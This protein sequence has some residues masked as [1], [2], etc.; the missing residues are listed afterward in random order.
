MFQFNISSLLFCFRCVHFSLPLSVPPAVWYVSGGGGYS[1]MLC[2]L[3]HSQLSFPVCPKG[4]VSLPTEQ[5]GVLWTAYQPGRGK[6]RI[7]LNFSGKVMLLV[8]LPGSILA[9][10]SC[11]YVLGS[12]QPIAW[13]ILCNMW[14]QN[15][16]PCQPITLQNQLL[17]LSSLL[18]LL[19]HGSVWLRVH[20]S[21][22]CLRWRRRFQ[23]HV[24]WLTNS[25]GFRPYLEPR[26]LTSSWYM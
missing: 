24:T 1:G 20:E 8:S 17:F 10:S 7:P 4:Q 26:K 14:L 13:P 6:G 23:V 9:W 19:L 16:L 22:S 11:C 15:W 2:E 12:E 3:V 21:V 5:G 18:C 25:L